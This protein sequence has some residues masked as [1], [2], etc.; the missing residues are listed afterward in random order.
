MLTDTDVDDAAVRQEFDELVTMTAS[1]LDQW[2]DTEEARSLA[3]PHAW[4]AGAAQVGSLR[5]V[6]VLRTPEADL[7]DLD[8]AWMRTVVV[9][10]RR[11]LEARPQDPDELERWRLELKS[12][13]HDPVR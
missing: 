7:T 12:W 11:L 5:V 8:R 2:L 6:D 4:D 13:G 1:E 3:D 9:T 10:V